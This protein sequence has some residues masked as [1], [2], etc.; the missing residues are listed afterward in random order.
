MKGKGKIMTGDKY[1][2]L[3]SRTMN[4]KLLRFQTELHA[5]HGLAGEV[6]EIHSIYQKVYQG[7]DLDTEHLK[8]EIGDLLWFVAELCTVFG[9]NMGE[10]AQKNIDKLKKRYPD[11][12]DEDRSI[13]RDKYSKE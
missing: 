8:K 6:G 7:H 4:P 9:F 13:N 11:G 2:E 10:I 12:F 5:V 3:A 1:Q